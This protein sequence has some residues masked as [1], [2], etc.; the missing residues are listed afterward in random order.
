[1]RRKVYRVRRLLPRSRLAELVAEACARNWPGD[2]RWYEAGEWLGVPPQRVAEWANN[3]SVPP[4]VIW[5]RLAALLQMGDSVDGIYSLVPEAQ[6]RVRDEREQRAGWLHSLRRADALEALMPKEP[7]KR[8]KRKKLTAEQIALRMRASHKRSWRRRKARARAEKI[9]AGIVAR[10][11][12]WRERREWVRGVLG[13]RAPVAKDEVRSVPGL[14]DAGGAGQ[15][16]PCDPVEAN[17]VVE[18]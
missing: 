5:K 17:T 14:A 10:E 16:G 3:R 1:M 12:R 6:E 2:R 15:P 9:R 8:R 7:R 13:H 18:R 11:R 4:L